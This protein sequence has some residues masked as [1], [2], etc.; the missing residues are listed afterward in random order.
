MSF[1][2]RIGYVPQEVSL[3][4]DT[5]AANIAFGCDK[6]LIDL[7]KVKMA[8]QLASLENFIE[9]E[10]SSA[11]DTIIGENGITLSGGQRQRL[12]IARALFSNPDIIVFDEA[13]KCT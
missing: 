2:S 4:S 11:Y 12:G 1:S 8:A 9:N 13:T 10:L 6:S 5:I 7:K 3:I